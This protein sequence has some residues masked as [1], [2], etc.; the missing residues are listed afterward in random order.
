MSGPGISAGSVFVGLFGKFNKKDFDDFDQRVFKAQKVKD[1]KARL[2]GDFDTRDFDMYDRRLKETRERTSLR[3]A[4]KATLGADYDARA[5]NAYYRDL[6]KARAATAAAAAEPGRLSRAFDGLAKSATK[7]GGAMGGGGGL[8]RILPGVG[9]GFIA[10]LASVSALLP[11]LLSVAG[12]ATALTASL[13]AAAAGASA[14]GVGIAAALGPLAAVAGAVAARVSVMSEAFKA[15]GTE[16]V[17]S[18][19]QASAAAEQQRAAGQRVKQA[20]EAVTKARF[21]ARRE[22][23]DLT[24]AVERSTRAEKDAALALRETQEASAA[25][26]ADPRST[27]LQRDRAREDLA[28]AKARVKDAGTAHR[29]AVTDEKRGTDTL[30]QAVLAL[31]EARHAAEQAAKKEGAAASDAQE[32][33]A[34][35]SA[36]ERKLVVDF[37]AFVD[38]LTKTFKPATDAIFGSVD[39]GL[40]LLTPLIG[41]FKGRFGEIGQAV[42]DVVDRAGKSLT[43]P[44]WVRALDTFA[45]TSRRVV[46]PVG[47][48][49][50]SVLEALRNIAV[51]AQP[52][53]VR[54]ADGIRDALGGFADKTADADKVRDV[55]KGLVDQTKSWLGFMGAVGKLIYTI[56]NGGAKQGQGLLDQITGIVKGWTAFLETD[57]GQRKMREF[58]KDSIEMTKKIAAFLSDV[59]DALYKVGR[60]FQDHTDLIKGMAAAWVS[61]RLAALAALSVTKGKKVI[62]FFRGTGAKGGGSAAADVATGAAGG[63][64]VAKVFSKGKDFLKGPGKG[65]GRI[66][67]ATVGATLS[68]TLQDPTDEMR[69]RGMAH[70][71]GKTLRKGG[72]DGAEVALLDKYAQAIEK[73]AK[74]GD[75]DGMRK[76]ADQLRQAAAANRDLTKGENLNRFADALDQT[77][78]RGGKDISSIAAAFERLDRTSESHLES[79]RQNLNDLAD[80]RSAEEVG[81]VLKQT[82]KHFEDFRN[83]GSNNLN[84]LHM[85]TKDNMHFIKRT[86]GEESEAGKKALVG[87]FKQAEDAVRAAMADG[88][89]TTRDGLREIRRLMKEELAVYGIKGQQATDYMRTSGHGSGNEQRGGG[90]QR[91]G[92]VRRAVGGW[93]G[94]RGM[95]SDDIVPIG[96]NAIAAFGEYLA[97]GS[98]G[99][100]AVINRH[101]A[102]YVDAALGAS[103]MGSLDTIPAHGSLSMIERAMA[104]LGGL[105]SLF[106]SVRTPHYLAGGGRLQSAI[107]GLGNKLSKMF[108]LQVTSTTGG[109]HAPGSFHGQGLAEDLG[110]PGP[111]MARAVTYIKSSG[112]ARS[113][114]E[115]IHKP[116]LS[117]KNG[118][119][120]PSSFWGG[121]WDE[122]ANHI[123]IALRALGAMTGLGSKI[124]APKVTGGGALGA[125]VGG[126]L[127]SVAAG[128]RAKAARLA[129]NVGGGDTAPA[130]ATQKSDSGVVSAFRR[131]IQTKRAKPVER[132]ALWEAGIVE[133]GL[134]NLNYGDADSLGSLQE[135]VSVYGRAHAMSPLASAI[136]FLSQAAALRPWKG[137]AG[138]LAQAVQ[139]SAFPDRYDAVASQAR[140]YLASG[141]RAIA[142]GSMGSSPGLGAG[143]GQL[144]GKLGQVMKSGWA[145]ARKFFPRSQPTPPDF[146]VS[147]LDPRA[148]A[149]AAYQ[150][151]DGRRRI[152]LSPDIVASLRHDQPQAWHAI[153]HEWAHTAQNPTLRL[154]GAQSRWLVEGGAEAFAR[155]H[156]S[157]IFPGRA[158]SF[159]AYSNFVK[160][161]MGDRTLGAAFV[162]KTQFQAGFGPQATTGTAKLRGFAGGGRF[163]SMGST[164]GSPG[165]SYATG[166]AKQFAALDHLQVGRVKA[167]D[168]IMDADHGLIA[169]DEKT[170]SQKER[171]YNQT[172]E[173]LVD[174]DGKLNTKA[175]DDR[176]AELRDLKT[177]RERIAKRYDEA[178]K[179]ARRVVE[180]YKT[181]VARLKNSLTYGDKKGRDRSGIKTQLGQ[182]QADLKT[183]RQNVQDREFDVGGQRLD[184]G[185]LDKEIAAVAG[186][187]AQSKP[188]DGDPPPSP[189]T[190][191][192]DAVVAQIQAVNDRLT[193]NLTA[194]NN[195][196][197]TFSS[198]GDIGTGGSNAI[199]AVGNEAHPVGAQY[200]PAGSLRS[201]AD[202]AP[203]I[204]HTEYHY[205]MPGAPHVLRAIGDAATAGQGMQASIPSSVTRLGI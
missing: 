126:G 203:T 174:D 77:A 159:G 193:G 76:L 47:D 123:H 5:F 20:T 98:D 3:G 26:L 45:E 106:A 109:K 105:D 147:K 117:I 197:A 157:Q 175:I 91:G 93:I 139:G 116:G 84:G 135:R 87:N 198:S 69:A 110:G 101:Q 166:N 75:K 186:T 46:K 199:N 37:K 112:I 44:E 104:P 194:A 60:Y 56:F 102:P 187:T 107:S 88:K 137:T 161:V 141:G 70:Y 39:R 171:T 29:R 72:P 67:G 142:T 36:T 24:A 89:V 204:N 130:P 202:A 179:I 113:L 129:D 128:A 62:D 200:A 111:A 168:R 33:L 18:G 108:G 92:R 11:A 119:A 162:D 158:R 176:V 152:A 25:V 10:L 151:H 167:Y 173:V 149:H 131:A 180:T 182:Y 144:T 78:D 94:G 7:A 81:R 127:K 184:L 201:A 66:F 99:R 59:V 40:L 2:E 13:A 58:F 183:W 154:G 169:V 55:L 205:N 86:L 17:K 118:K 41:R 79:V 15:L 61:Y 121:V 156:G 21:D 138:R 172:D 114:L 155:R 143:V 32:K 170:Y 27:A 1:I 74:A 150:T 23:D 181:I 124:R 42:A 85:A 38:Q 14:V 132:L 9:G 125:V 16:Q 63:S 28:D 73:V 136:R 100:K 90:H 83:T 57:E 178:L 50:G 19:A 189:D 191:N 31:A 4:I 30:K 34:K 6:M 145:R 160:R 196:I 68:D 177:I 51:A 97:G 43:S 52:Y 115:G 54:L 190:S 120:V 48:S 35:L 22:T 103:G 82:E 195:V 65:L 71:D 64:V 192:A 49:I 53:V 134:K 80:K 122:H 146:V 12:A 148:W 133:S 165:G 164:G 153:L 188:T 96:D 8:A 140:R 95:V 163:T 185:D